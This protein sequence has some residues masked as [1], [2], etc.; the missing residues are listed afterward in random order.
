MDRYSTLDGA[1]A[2]DVTASGIEI[3]ATIPQIAGGGIGGAI[4]MINVGII[5][6]SMN[7]S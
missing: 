5:K 6:N 2:A 3:G 1:A 4:L 7:K